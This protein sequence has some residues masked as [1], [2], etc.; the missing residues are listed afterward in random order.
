[1]KF[2]EKLKTNLLKVK[3]SSVSTIR[4]KTIPKLT[5]KSRTTKQTLEEIFN[6]TSLTKISKR[7]VSCGHRY[8]RTVNNRLL[9]EGKEDNFKALKRTWGERI[10]NSILFTHKDSIYLE[11]F[12]IQA[13]SKRTIHEYYWEDGT[14]VTKE[15]QKYL[16]INFLP[17]KKTESRQGT[18]E[19]VKLNVIKLESIN[20][21]KGYGFELKR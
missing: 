1:M 7:Y 2:E 15:E 10:G 16:E 18:D 4:T 17:I 8:S 20:E 11:C 14:E 3:G 12:Y 19:E 13:N 21:F 6:H 5:K 9:K